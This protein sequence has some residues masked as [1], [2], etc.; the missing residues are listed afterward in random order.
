VDQQPRRRAPA[1]PVYVALA[2][3]LLFGVIF[4]IEFFIFSR[5]DNGAVDPVDDTYMD[6][7]EPLLADADP[8]RGPQLVQRHGCN[9]CHAGESAG[10]LAPG[11]DGLGRVAVQRRP[12]LQAEAYIY[13]SII[14]PGT[15]V[16]DGFQN[17]MPR[18]YEAQIPE[19]ELGD[20]IAYLLTR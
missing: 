20:I 17:N 12:P 8:E 9:A 14:H 4:A 19:D 3:L 7:V 6:I 2:I 11:F 18:I 15:Y 10:R 1:W 5:G 16:V 13:E